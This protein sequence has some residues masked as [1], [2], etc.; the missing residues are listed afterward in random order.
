MI[1]N[2]GFWYDVMKHCNDNSKSKLTE[3]QIATYAYTYTDEWYSS[4][5]EKKLANIIKV[6]LE[7]LKDDKTTEAE[8]FCKSI[9]TEMD[10]NAIT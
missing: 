7:R 3:K 6:L 4:M 2:Y 10:F 9:E 8:N 1:L 5:R